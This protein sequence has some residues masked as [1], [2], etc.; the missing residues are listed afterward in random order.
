[1]SDKE[2]IKSNEDQNEF[3]K[4]SWKAE[5]LATGK[6]KIEVK[7]RANTVSEAEGAM[8]DSIEAVQKI[9]LDKKLELTT[10]KETKV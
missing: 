9:L 4:Y 3:F 7:V 2:V 8:A 10:G 6:F 5:Q 1:M